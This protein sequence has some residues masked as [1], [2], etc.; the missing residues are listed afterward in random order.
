MELIITRNRNLQGLRHLGNRGPI[1]PEIMSKMH[2]QTTGIVEIQARNSHSLGRSHFGL[3]VSRRNGIDN[4]L[5]KELQ[6]DSND[7]SPRSLER[8]TPEHLQSAEVSPDINELKR[9]EFNL[10][11]TFNIFQLRLIS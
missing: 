3:S 10:R 8:L 4:R 9:K 1:L 6:E 7:G 11:L 5:I 2:F